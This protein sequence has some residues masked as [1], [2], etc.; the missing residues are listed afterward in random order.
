MKEIGFNRKGLDTIEDE[1]EVIFVVAG[2]SIIG[3]LTLKSP[4]DDIL[5]ML[6]ENHNFNAQEIEGAILRLKM[7]K[8]KQ[9]WLDFIRVSQRTPLDKIGLIHRKIDDHTMGLKSLNKNIG[10]LQEEIMNL[11]IALGRELLKLE[12]QNME[13][14]E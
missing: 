5:G 12:L 7:W 14:E 8:T 4:D 2:G 13:S 11:N 6:K 1:F 3:S 10:E 9:E